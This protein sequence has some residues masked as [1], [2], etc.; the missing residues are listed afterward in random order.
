M[1]DIFHHKQH[2]ATFDKEDKK[3]ILEYKNFDIENSISLS[4]PNT[5]KY[6]KN[7][8]EIIPYF[9]IFL[10]EGYLFEVF[11]NYLTKNYGYIDDYLLFSILAPN[12]EGRI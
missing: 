1:S 8:Y 10:P 6:Y 7:E 4:L 5:Q 12:I 9:D 11:K 3:Y 2:I